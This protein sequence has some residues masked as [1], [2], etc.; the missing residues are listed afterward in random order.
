[1]F[2]TWPA[3]DTRQWH[4]V[5]TGANLMQ[6]INW[7]EKRINA[8]M[9]WIQPL[10]FFSYISHTKAVDYYVKTLKTEVLVN[11]PE[12]M[13]GEQVEFY[14]KPRKIEIDSTGRR[15]AINGKIAVQVSAKTK[16]DTMKIAGYVIKEGNYLIIS[17]SNSN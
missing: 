5:L 10:A 8:T 9:G 3:K 13:I 4:L 17:N 2:G 11:A 1:M 15:L 14:F 7:T 16:L 12:L 6:K